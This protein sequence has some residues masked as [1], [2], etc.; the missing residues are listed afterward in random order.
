MKPVELYARVRHACHVEGMSQREAARRFGID[1]KTVAKMLRHAV[2]PG[3][4]RTKAPTRPRLDA[5]TAIIDQILISDRSAPPKQRHT[6]K[7]IHDR[8]RAEHGFV[9]GYTTIKDYVREQRAR[10]REVFVPLVHPPGHAQVDFGEAVAVIGG[11]RRKV[12]LFCLDLPHSDACF[13]KAYPA[14][15]IEAFL[16]GHNAAFAF[17]GGVPRSILYDNTRLAVARI[18]GDGER[19]RTR[20]FAELQSHYLFLASAGPAKATTRAR[21]RA[22]S[23]TP[24]ATS[25]SRSRP[26]PASPTSTPTSSGA[27]SIAW[28]IGCVA[29]PRASAS[30]WSATLLPCSHGHR[31]PTTLATAGRHGSPRSRSCATSATTTRC[32]PPTATARCWCGAMSRRW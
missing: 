2:P 6:A 28:V 20:A 31:C 12:H 25:W 13:V 23:A 10:T 9:G 30:D 21:S 24:G 19:Q 8:L 22:W 5:F 1:P 11:E 29:M 26:S 4:R 7:R 32:R 3:Y 27:A 17:L 15:R 14:E 18:L 16:D